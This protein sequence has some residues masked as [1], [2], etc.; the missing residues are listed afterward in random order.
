MSKHACVHPYRIRVVLCV[1]D[2]AQTVSH[3]FTYLVPINCKIIVD[4]QDFHFD[5]DFIS[6][7]GQVYYNKLS[8]SAYFIFRWM[9]LC[10]HDPS[11]FTYLHIHVRGATYCRCARHFSFWPW[12]HIRVFLHTLYKTGDTLCAWLKPKP[13]TYMYLVNCTYV[14]PI[15][16]TVIV[17][18]LHTFHF[19]LDYIP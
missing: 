19:Y 16:C 6:D 4:V 9:V 14:V 1:R 11:R 10:V 12:L 5:L 15:N 8:F 3:I 18:V 17:D 2:S 13:F 7:P